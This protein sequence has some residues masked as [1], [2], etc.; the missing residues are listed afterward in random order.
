MIKFVRI[1]N[2]YIEELR[3]VDNRVQ[4][5]SPVNGKDL[6]PFVGALFQL[7][8]GIQY[9]V[10]LSSPKAKHYKMKNTSSFQ[11]VY[12]KKKKLRAVI[13]FNNMVPV[14]QSL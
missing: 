4:S 2:Q 11:K 13:N 8:D 3:K 5:N 12:N 1:S 14:V 10:P 6:K 7:D 9:F